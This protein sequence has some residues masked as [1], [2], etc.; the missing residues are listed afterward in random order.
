MLI[1]QSMET[2]MAQV[3]LIA[4]VTYLRLQLKLVV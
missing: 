4:E 1:S 2:H 3:K